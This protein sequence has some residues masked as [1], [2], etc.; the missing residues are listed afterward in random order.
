MV[1]YSG[2]KSN[3]IKKRKNITTKIIAVCLLLLLIP[4]AFPIFHFKEE[5]KNEQKINPSSDTKVNSPEIKSNEPNQ[6][7]VRSSPKKGKSLEKVNKVIDSKKNIS[8]KPHNELPKINKVK[9]NMRVV[10]KKFEL[11][12]PLEVIN[13]NI[14]KLQEVEKELSFKKEIAPNVEISELQRA[15][16]DFRNIPHPLL[17]TKEKEKIIKEILSKEEEDSVKR[18]ILKKK[19][20]F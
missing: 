11:E 9:E 17:D 20:G 18:W 8:D 16:E 12:K 4:F 13:P 19:T 2:K 14:V 3:T 7:S 6:G 15:I 1:H 5:S 10:Q